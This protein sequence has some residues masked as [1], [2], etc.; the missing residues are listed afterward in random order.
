MLFR[1]FLRSVPA[2]RDPA[3]PPVDASHRLVN[4]YAG[5]CEETSLSSETFADFAEVRYVEAVG[6]AR[7]DLAPRTCTE[8]LGEDFLRVLVPLWIVVGEPSQN[9]ECVY[10]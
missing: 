3:D 10:V 4:Q 1:S 9:L 7:R 6:V 8:S 2:N 5:L